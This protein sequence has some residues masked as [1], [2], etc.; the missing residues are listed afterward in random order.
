MSDH[1][2]AGTEKTSSL[3]A[4][5]IF[6]AMILMGAFAIVGYFYAT[7]RSPPEA[8][9]IDMTPIVLTVG[10]APAPSSFEIFTNGTVSPKREIVGTAEVA[11]KI[12][13][14]YESCDAGRF[15]KQ[16]D[17]L[18]EIDSSKY[19]LQLQQLENEIRQVEIDA[20]ELTIEQEKNGN[21]IGIGEED[22]ALSQRE[23]DRFDKLV[24]QKSASASQ[25]DA[26]STKV[27]QSKNALQQLVSQRSILKQ[28]NEKLITQ[29]KVIQTKIDLAK[30]DLARTKIAAPIDGFITEDLV[31]T[32]SYVQPGTSLFKIEDRSAVEVRCNLKVEDLYWLTASVTP[33]TSEPAA[34]ESLYRAPRVPAIVEYEVAGRTYR[35][36][37]CFLSRYEGTGLN[38]RTR[39]IPCRVE[40]PNPDRGQKV[41]DLPPLVRGM[42][43]NV[44][45]LATPRENLLKIPYA[46]LRPNNEV[47]IARGD[48]L[49]IQ[50]V[51]VA[52]MLS[53]GVLLHA[54][55]SKLRPGEDV[56][57][58]PLSVAINRMK[59]RR[60][61]VVPD[62]A[63]SA[64]PTTLP[65]SEITKEDRPEPTNVKASVSGKDS[66]GG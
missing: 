47:W 31:E 45:L 38:E 21:L 33:S 64:E 14:K 25:R 51:R 17:P 13:K 52:K 63:P 54:G 60:G 4:D 20:L 37:D 48:S 19:E 56:I 43:V 2:S 49:D 3:Y 26:Q 16:G 40:V 34:V 7:R 36:E 30:L 18:V 35:W 5:Y 23:L 66:P 44:K 10:V 9:R 57:I 55:D 41:S 53:D 61:D 65:V 46:A 62:D 28:R 58:S 27:M 50:R 6:P 1:E 22:L 59:I 42:F 11:G 24:N 32:S 29:R 8:A 12:T 15:V 39:T